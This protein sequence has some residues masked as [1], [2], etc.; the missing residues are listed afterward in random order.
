MKNVKPGLFLLVLLI[1]V[2]A[3]FAKARPGARGT[4]YY[5]TATGGGLKWQLA[6][7]SGKSCNTASALACII[8]SNEPQA[9][10]L[11][12]T[13]SFPATYTIVSGNAF[14]YN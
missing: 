11:A 1:G 9:T 6:P 14:I 4:L 3:A 2:G 7:P 5:G 13:N 12:L 10:V 8:F